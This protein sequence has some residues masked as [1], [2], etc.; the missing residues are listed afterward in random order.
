MSRADAYAAFYR[1]SRARLLVQVYAYCGDT[2]VAQRALSDAYV[3]AAHHWRK[4]A[5][6]PDPDPWM[7]ERAFRATHSAQNRARKPWYVRAK[8]TADEHRDL[9]LVLQSLAPVDRQLL[10]LRWLAGHDQALAARESGLTDEAA[11]ASLQASA[12]HLRCVAAD[13]SPDA[14]SS[15]LASLRHDL[16]AEP[17]ELASRLRREGNRR[18]HTHMTLAG[19]LSLALVI[20]AGALTAAKSPLTKAPEASAPTPSSPSATTPDQNKPDPPE[21]VPKLTFDASELTPLRD[22]RKLRTPRPWRLSGTSPDFG[23]TTPYDD[24]LVAVPSDPRAEHSLVRTFESSPG[25]R[26]L[27]ATQSLEVSRSTAAADRNYLRLVKTYSGCLA[28]NHQV[29][30]YALMRGVG[31]AGSLITM[32]YVDRR[33][34]HHQQVAIAKSGS[35]VITWIVDSPSAAPVLVTRLVVLTASSVHRVCAAAAG[36][37]GRRPYLAVEQPPPRLDRATGFLTAVDLPVFDDLTD[38]WVPTRLR[39]A[40][41]NP[42]ATECDRADFVGAGAQ[43]VRARSFVVPDAQRLPSIFGMTETVGRFASIDDAAAFLDQVDTS[44]Q[45]CNERQVSLRVNATSP[46][47]VTRGNGRTYE[48]ILSASESRTITFRVALIRVGTQVAQ[49]TFTPSTRFD[50]SPEEFDRVVQRA[51]LRVTQA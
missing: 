44:V 35:S 47:A 13:P 31:D 46:I 43:Q 36:S 17:A 23:V 11:T 22:M 18:R 19:L 29:E 37:C 26:P 51:A 20:G 6:L 40:R 2:E 48:I 32:R 34:I 4:L 15:A 45:G 28:D 33:G 39:T 9:L 25:R 30:R 24:C 3:A 16:T 49:I 12:D 38:P 5:L 7:R 1:D 27:V 8:K 14:I 41:V 10:I 21:R 42:A 50:M